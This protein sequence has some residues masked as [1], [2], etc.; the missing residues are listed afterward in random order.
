MEQKSKF[1]N[2]REYMANGL[3]A[4]LEDLFDATLRI[5]RDAIRY[6]MEIASLHYE[7]LILLTRYTTNRG[8]R[9]TAQQHR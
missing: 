8:K 4:D 2:N 6:F 1:V 3:S 7:E 9:V 5:Y